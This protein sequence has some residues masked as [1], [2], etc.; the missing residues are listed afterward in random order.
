MG[1]AFK[2]FGEQLD[3]V[4]DDAM[5]HRLGNGTTFYGKRRSNYYGPTDPNRK[6]LVNRFDPTEDY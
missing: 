5:N 2:N 6:V 3:A 1:V 4:V